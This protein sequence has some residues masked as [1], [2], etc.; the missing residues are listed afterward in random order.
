MKANR[1][2]DKKIAYSS[3]KFVGPEFRLHVRYL[4]FHIKG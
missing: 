3:E 1:R 2:L 4:I